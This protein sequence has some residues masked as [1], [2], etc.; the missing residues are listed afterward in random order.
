[1]RLA[2]ALSFWAMLLPCLVLS[3]TAPEARYTPLL[4]NA[5]VSVYRL[6]LTAGQRAPVFQNTHDIFWVALES[7]TLVFVRKDEST[8]SMQLRAGDTRFFP[9]FASKQVRNEGDAPFRG[10]IVEI[11][12]RGLISQPCDCLGDAEKALC[13]CSPAPALPKLW[14]AGLGR[15]TAGGTTL[16]PGEG[17]YSSTERGDTVLIALTPLHL[18]DQA[19]G[20]DPTIS[21]QP[22]EVAWIPRGRYKW[23]NTAASPAR[24]ITIEF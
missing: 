2:A 12:A 10:V 20:A 13:G 7:G 4:D 22:G 1:M 6:D 19:T 21:L 3:Q 17:F 18:S 23:K 14:A 9:S 15:V 24:Y 8:V 16:E 5:Q 11:K